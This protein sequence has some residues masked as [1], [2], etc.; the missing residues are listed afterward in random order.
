MGTREEK[1]KEV[2]Q[3]DGGRMMQ[4]QTLVFLPLVGSAQDRLLA[5]ICGI[6]EIC[7]RPSS[8]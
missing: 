8:L 2:R 7:D 3:N 4:T 6:C 5:F 1:D